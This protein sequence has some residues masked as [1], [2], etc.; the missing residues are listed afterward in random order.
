M[1]DASTL[2]LFVGASLRADGSADEG[3]TLCRRVSAERL[4]QLEQPVVGL[5]L[6]DRHPGAFARERADDDA[7]LVGRRRELRGPLA[8]LEPDEV[9]LRLRDV[10]ARLAQPGLHPVPFADQ[11]VHPLEQR[12]L[13]VERSDG[14]G[15]G[16]P[17]DTERQRHRAQRG[18]ERL[19]ATA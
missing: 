1:P 9:A 18:G 11:R 17:G 10:P 13:G 8:Q 19:L 12:G 7:Q 3:L 2:L 4:R 16:D 6:A 5:V 14:S 15:L